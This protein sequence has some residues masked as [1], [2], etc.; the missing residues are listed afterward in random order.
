MN[1][2]MAASGETRGRGGRI[3]FRPLGNLIHPIHRSSRLLRRVSRSSSTTEILAA[4]DATSNEPY[5]KAILSGLNI[6]LDLQFP[7]DSATLASLS[8]FVR[9]LQERLNKIDLAAIKDTCDDGKLG[10][11]HWRPGQKLLADTITKDNTVTANLF[12][13]VLVTGLHSQPY[14]T[15]T[16]LGPPHF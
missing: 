5:I 10:A 11:S 9:E 15:R 7:V 16:I 14:E 13:R 4:A 6:H 12:Y 3:I 8:T 2:D 1:G